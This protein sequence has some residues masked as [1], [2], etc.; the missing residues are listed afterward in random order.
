MRPLAHAVLATFPA[1]LPAA[2]IDLN[3]GT[4]ARAAGGGGR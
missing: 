3:G 4:R 1:P 2:E